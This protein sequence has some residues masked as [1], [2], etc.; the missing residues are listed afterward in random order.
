MVRLK[1]PISELCSAQYTLKYSTFNLVTLNMHD[2]IPTFY[3]VRRCKVCFLNNSITSNCKMRLEYT[4]KYSKE[5]GALINR[6]LLTFFQ[7]GLLVN[8]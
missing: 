5:T 7:K 8:R 1:H 6:S 2:H 4:Y 3:P